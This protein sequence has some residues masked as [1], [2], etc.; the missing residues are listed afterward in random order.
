M[1][2]ARPPICWGVAAAL[3]VIGLSTG[4]WAAAGFKIPTMYEAFSRVQLCSFLWIAKVKLQ[5]QRGP[6]SWWGKVVQYLQAA[7]EAGYA[8][9]FV[10]DQAAGVPSAGISLTIQRSPLSCAA[11]NSRVRAAPAAHNAIVNQRRLTCRRSF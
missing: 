3:G 8:E 4:S 5:C 10:V 7:L 2:F 6:F 11:R 1:S 9:I